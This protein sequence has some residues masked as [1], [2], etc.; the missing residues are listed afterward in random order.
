MVS[1]ISLKPP[2]K[3]MAGLMQIVYRELRAYSPFYALLAM[4]SPL[5]YL[6]LLW[7]DA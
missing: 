1:P 4:G 6:L 7:L 2:M 5:L 3:K